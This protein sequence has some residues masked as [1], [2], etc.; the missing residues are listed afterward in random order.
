[1][2]RAVLL[3]A[4][5]A[6]CATDDDDPVFCASNCP[7]PDNVVQDVEDLKRGN[8][9][10]SAYFSSD[11]TTASA[12]TVTVG[13]GGLTDV[14]GCPVLDAGL[15]ISLAGVPGSIKDAGGAFKG[16]HWNC[17]NL[18]LAF[19]PMPHMPSATLVI[20]DD[21][22]E[23]SFDLGDAL[24]ARSVEAV[25][26]SDWRFTAGQ[27]ATFRWS[28]EGD[29]A[30]NLTFGIAWDHPDGSVLP[31]KPITHVDPATFGIALPPGDGTALWFSPPLLRACGGNCSLNVFSQ[32]THPAE[33][34]P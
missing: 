8:V 11:S 30:N 18:S 12:T 1:M 27:T 19:P 25:S 17:G 6:G 2:S 3:L 34:T 31:E 22:G 7:M 10:V 14:P 16:A 13:F 23:M 28:P 9:S 15:Q 33:V 24:F 4:I 5:L 20:S 32:V 26:N 21:S 29:V